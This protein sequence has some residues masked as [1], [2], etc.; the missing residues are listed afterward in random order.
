MDPILYI[1]VGGVVWQVLADGTWLQVPA[2]QPKVEGVQVVSIEP[3]NLDQTQ[4]LTE[5]QIAAVEQQLEE[6]VTQLVNNIES[7]PEQPSAS[8]DQPSASASFIAYVR[9]TLDE[10]LAE[11]GFDTRPT[12]YFEDDTTS[13]DGELDVLLPSAVLTVDILDGGD[14]YENQFEVP[15]VTITGT[16]VDVRDGRTV[17]LTITDVNGNTVT[18]TAITNDETY[19]VNG[20]DLSSLAEGDLKVDAIIADD[21]GNSITANDSTIKDTLATIDVDFDGFGDEFYNK[22]EVDNGALVGTVTN[23]EDGQTISITITDS[24]GLSVSYS[25]VVSGNSWTLENQDYSNFAEGEL[26][27]VASTIDIAGNPTTASDT[28]VKDTLASIDVDFDGFGDE[29][30]NELEVNNG[31]LVGTVSN[32]EDGQTILITITDSE[33]LSVNYSTVVSGD[34]WT[35][36]NQDYSNFAEGELTVVAS[37]IDIAGNPT[38][39][40]DTIVKDTLDRILVRFD[41]FGDNYY[42]QSEVSKG[43]LIGATFNIEDGQAIN[44]TI[45]DSNGFSVDYTSVVSGNLWSLKD[46]DYSGFAEGELTVVASITDIAGNTISSTDTIIKDTLVEIGVEFSGSDDE[47]YNQTEVLNGV[48]VGTVGNVEDGQTISITITDSA[49]T[50]LDYSTT[51]S[52][53]TWTLTDQDYSSFAEGELTVEA[54][55]TDIAG[56]TATSV[57][58]ILKD[59]LADISV[60]FDGFGDEYYNSAEVSNGTLVGSVTNVEDGQEVS[61]TITDVDGKSENYTATVSGGEWTLTGQDYSAFAEGTLTV[62]ATVTDVAGN[63]ATSSDIIVKDTLADISVNFDGF[64]DEYYNSAEVSNGALVGTVT[65]V[66]DGQEVSIIITDVDG[67]SENYTATVT[68][69]EWTLT[70]QD[71]SA[72]AEGTLTVEATVTDIAGNTATS[73]DTIVKDT[74]A[75][76]SVDFDGFGDE[77]YNSAEV[78]NGTLVGSVTNV[79]D[80]QEVSITIT[81][82]DGKSENYTAIVTGGEWT[83]V[84]QDYSGF[85]EG[86]LTVEATVTDVAG[87]TATSSDTIVKDT[88]ADIS[89]DFDGFGDEYYNSAEVSNGTLVGSVTNVEDGQEVSITI[90]DVDGKSENYTATV[91]G[92]EWTLTGQDY[93]AFAEGTLTVEATVTDVAGNTATSSDIIVKDTLADISVNFDGFGDEY[94]NSAEVSNGALVGTVTNVEDGQEVSIIITDVDGKSENYTATVTGGEWTLTDQDYS[95][96]AE[97]T[98]TVEATV[99]DI[100]GNTA[101]SSDTIVK[102][103]LADISVD[104]DGFGD[105][106]YNSAEVSNGTLVG[107]VTNVEDGQ[108]VSITITDVDGKSENYTAIVTGGEWTLVGQDYSGFAEGILTVE[109]TVTDVAGNTATSSDTIV[110]DTLADISVDFDGFGDEYYNSAEVS[111]GT[112]VG[113]VTNVEDGQEVSIT[114]TDV[115]GKS[116]NYTATV[117]GGEWT[118]TGQDYSAFAEGTL[119]VEAT[120]TDVAGNTATSSDTIVKDTLADISVN[121]D[122]FGDEYYNSA[123]VSNGALVGTVTN[124]E[125]GQEVSIIIT[126]VDGKSENYTATVTGGEWTLIGQD[127]SAFAEGTLTVEATVTDIAGNTATSSDTIVKDTLADISVNFDGFGDEYYNSAEVSNGALVGTVT[128]VEDGQEVSITITDVDGKLENYTAIVTGGEWTL[129]GQDYSGFAEGILTVEASVTDVAGNTVTSSDTIVKDTLASITAEFDDADNILNT[130]EVQSVRLQGVVQNVEDGQP[131]TVTVTDSNNQSITLQ[132][133]V[134]AGAWIIDDVDLSAFADGNIT[135]EAVTVDIAGNETTG[136]DSTGQIDTAPPVIDIDTLSGFNILDFRSGDLTTMQGT[137]DVSEGLPVYIEI[138]DGTQT[139]T[140]EGVIDASGGWLVENIDISSL[141]PSTEWIID[142]RVVNSIGNEASDDMPSIVLPGSVSFSE[143]TVGIFGDQTQVADINIQFADEFAF[144][145][146]QVSAEG[147]TSQGQSIAIALESD[148]QVLKATRTDG[149]LVFEAKIVGDTVEITFFQAVDQQASEELLQTAIIIEGLQIDDDGTTELVLGELPITILDS[150]PLLFDESYTM[151]EGETSSGNVLSNDIDLDTALTISSVEVGGVSKD[152]S[153]ATPAVFN[154]GD[155][156]LTV[157]A[158]GQWTFEANRNLDHTQ[159]HTVTFNYVAADSSGDFGSATATIDITDGASGE[160]LDDSKTVTEVDVTSGSQTINAQFTILG[161]S[162]NPDPDSIQFSPETV[163]QL[164]A[165]GMTSGGDSTALSYTLS[166]DG[167]TITA[168]QGDDDVFSFSMTTTVDGNNVLADIVLVIERPLDHVLTSDLLTIPLN[169]IGTDTDGTALENGQISWVIEDGND[170]SLILDSNASVNESDLSNDP[171]GEVSSTGT[172]SVGI[173][174]DY[175]DSVFFELADQPQLFCGGEQIYY[176]VSEDGTLLTGYAGPVAGGDVAFTVSFAAPV[177]DDADSSVDYVFTLYKGLDQTNGTDFLPFTVT[178]RDSDNDDTKLDLNVSIT[179]GGE[180][181]IGSGT[182]ELSETPIADSTPS[183]VGSTANVSLAVT[184]GNDP[185]VF[186]GLDVTT[187]QAVLDSDGIAVTNNGEALTWRDNGNGTFDAVL[188]NGDAVFK[189]KLPDNFSLEAN[190]STSVDVVIELYQSIDHGSGSKDTELTIPASIVTID[191]DGSRDTQESDI[192]IYDGKDPTFSIVGSISVDEDGL[193]GDN[194]QAGTEEPSPSISIIQGSDDIASVSINID[195]FDDLGY[196]SG[197]RA[198][199]LQEVNADGWYYAQ[200]SSGNDIFRIRFNNDGTTEFNLYGPLDHATGDGE[201]NLAVNFELVVTDADGDSSDPAIYSVNVTDAVPTAR[202]GSIELVEGDN[203]NGQFLTEEFAG[204]DGATIIS[205]DY[206]GTTYTFVDADTPITIDLINDFDSGSV[207]G[208][209]TLSSDGSYQL[210]TNPNVTTDPDDPKIVD[211]IDYL[212]RDADGDEVVSNAELVLDDNE[213]FIRYEDSETT[214]DNDAII[215][216]SVS[217]GDI[218]QSETVTAI[219]FSE[220]S[221]NGGSLYLDGVLLQVVDGKV[222]L[223][224]SQLAAIDSQFTGPNGQLTYRPALHESNTTSTVILAINAIISTDT[225]P[226]ELTADIAVSV[227]PVADAPDWSDSVFTYQSVEDDATP[228]KLDITAQLVDQDSSETLTYTI[229]GIPDGLNITLNGNAV[230]EGKEYTQNQ[231]DKMEIRADENL[232]GRF[233]FEITAIATEAGNTFADPDD[234]TADI[235]N[236]VVVEISPDAD[237]PILSVKDYKGLEDENIFLKNVINGALTDTDGSESLSYQI[238]VQDGW[239]IQGGLFDLIGPNTYLV[240]AEAIENGTAYLIPKED[241]SSFTEDLF[242]NVTAVSYESTIDSLDPVN[243]TALSDTKTINIFLKGVVDEPV[244]VD[245]GNAHWEYD[246]DT[247][248]ISNQSVLNEDGLIRLDFVV[249]TSD[250]DVSEEINILLTNIPEGTLLVDALGEPVSLTIAYIDDVTGAVFQVSNAQLNDLYLKPVADFSGELELTVIAISTEPDGDSGEFPMTLKVEL[251]PVVDQ[252]DGQTVSTQ[253]I[254]DSQIGLNLEP[255][256][257][258]D[259]D[260]SESL[261]G[262]VIDSLPSDLTLYFDGS[263]IAVPDTGLDLESLLDSTTPTL[264]ELLNSGRLSVTATED[265]S[266]TFSIPITYEVTDTSPTGATDIKDISGSISVTVDARVESDTRLESSGQLYTSDDGSPVNVSNA[267]TFVDADMD[268]S[269]YLDYILI[270]VPDGYSLIIDHPNGAAQDISG[271]WIISANGL[272]S[273][274]IQELAQE[275]LSGMTIS[276]PSDTPVLDIVV[277]ARVI[278]GEDSKYIDTSFQIQITG[279]DGGGGSC[280]PVGPPSPIQPDGDIK[281]PEGQDIDLTGLLNT[282]VAS[283]PDNTISFYIPAD[284]LPEG[285]EISGDGVIAEYDAAGEVV[286]YSITAD[287]LSKLTLT[288]LDED[289]AGCIDFTIKTIETSSCSGETVTT[290]QTI[291][292]QVLPVVDDITVATDSTTIQEDI[293]TDLNLELVLGDSVEDGK[294]ITGEG[295]S[296]TGKETVNSLT[297][298]VSNGVT[299]SESPADTGLLVDNGNGTWTVTDPSRLSDVLVTPPEHYSGEITLTVTANITDEADCVTETDT[300]DKTTVVTITVEPV[301]DAANLV[302]QDVVGDEDNYISLSSLSAELIDQDGSENMS[303][304]LKG[305]PEGAIVAIKVGDSYEL[306]PN[307]GVD[308]GSFDGNPTYEWQL[309]PSQLADLVIMPPRDFSGDMNLVLEAITQEIGTTEIRYTESEFTVGVNPIGDKVEFF[310]LPEQLTGSEDEGIVIPL[311]A[312]SFETNSDEFLSITVTVN[313]TSDPSGLVGL[314]RIRIGSETSSFT[315]VNGIIQATII[316]KASSVDE[317]EFFAGDAFGNLDITITGR[318]V[319]QNTVLGELVVDTGDPSSQDMTL[320][321]T[322]E[323]DAP[324]LSVEYPSI[325]AE[326]SGTIPLGLDLSL[327]NP[328]D[329]EEGFITI[330]DIPAGLTFSHGSMV[331]GQYVVDLADVP[332]LA[333]TGGYNS[334]DQFELTIEPSAEIGNNQAVGL[335]Q[336]VS[337]E[338][339]AEGDSTIIATEDNDLLIG[340]TGS[341]NFVFESSGLGSA[342]A[343]SYDV[344][345]DFDASPNT[346]AIDLSGILGS[347][348]LNTGVGATQ[349]LD[350]EESGEGVT[351][352]IKPNGDEDV[353]QNILLADVTYDDLYQGDSSS[354]LEAQI[355]QKMIEDNNL[356]L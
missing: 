23:V 303:L 13:N 298:T 186:L 182:V 162:D 58:T 152:I 124:V 282:D 179:D 163:A 146:N 95:A 227:L 175:L 190:G 143:S 106:Y 346:D 200:D 17:V 237:T 230:K 87:N 197:G 151:V 188:G 272:T 78:S 42:N 291:S 2:S 74:L 57:D 349:Y 345:Q 210:T 176:T 281:T 22:F 5:P 268:G 8:N 257:N 259:V 225:V 253:G 317:L 77:Y 169:I 88:L 247:K 25:T 309:D 140:F 53:G 331:G 355:L 322:P 262:Y 315:N 148:G 329:S 75:D 70:D 274:S 121:F 312:N 130:E 214:E 19:V 117:S 264:S 28:I 195:A 333:I 115:D 353:Q 54:S 168:K 260:G 311:D 64:G 122:G 80:G 24:E 137:T 207:Y 31:A 79:E 56:N 352:S 14:G 60:D 149:T 18:T 101:T 277:R 284:S 72:F 293:T 138:N 48:L 147:I 83:L 135:V 202:S 67:K 46:Q 323:P 91:S 306:V 194:E 177:S 36:V 49:G 38:T 129:V 283:D 263:V 99:T 289:F 266:G 245:G 299:L 15:S 82:V 239:A 256:V 160:I 211:D 35:L 102:D 301:A 213:G 338:F 341:D 89:V 157:F 37:T 193:I 185:L 209:F 26:T 231:I 172:F 222:T 337:V 229:S 132:T 250:D 351:I 69:G 105:E 328:A 128:N 73:S 205:F 356:T 279:H 33:G 51:V 125:D 3:Q 198:I 273:D 246:S 192:K 59:T 154:T 310:D 232:A 63:T 189:I 133:M 320:I 300:Q 11:A 325:V 109:A 43:A 292:I 40:T 348:G 326:A 321:I 324:L 290:D 97:G 108:E 94:Y 271:N 111:N 226:K 280:D 30:Y 278:D 240:S 139:L 45:T 123:E 100:A 166:A 96:F 183:G 44:I 164:E 4:P 241:I 286:G 199:S 339:V 255:S 251:A 254:E 248:V 174:S 319:D 93:S 171:V 244:V 342:D 161:G 84:G 119:T 32:V 265:L 212:V 228:I 142:A 267:V 61:I 285:V 134:V 318:T 336:T 71:Y 181:F 233:E 110:K 136:T 118:L 85:A 252:E 150:E 104:F 242:I 302:T 20:V 144:S 340:G 153:G 16:A 347:L 50:S 344:V 350:L 234:R 327:V 47:V 304:A 219:E 9:S 29:F 156:V 39:A 288:G 184:A 196:T 62:E 275:I 68:G 208:Q 131:I 170:P 112:L 98:L 65:N 126:D 243:V 113:S 343:P 201:N 120:V 307:N 86:I 270:D 191:S 238:E 314:D 6:V 158:N 165:L 92:G 180:P 81:D 217:T 276:S 215:V 41:G 220:A 103:T 335:P 221:L 295:N 10:T 203:L 206:R 167:R 308:G 173:G 141:D 269:E 258:Q 218:D 235:V 12:E 159:D 334:G 55:V 66:E 313:S 330:Y 90:T 216:V 249:Q 114:I 127:Y 21:F 354:A 7:S 27:V 76:I 145:A 52:G 204:A 261:T 34:S 224:G 332:N 294:L 155:G 287:G 236:T 1:E 178:A 305:V 223:S 296:A 316:V 107:S 297:I 116:E 187:G